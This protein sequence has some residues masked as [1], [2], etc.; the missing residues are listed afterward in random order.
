MKTREELRQEFIKRLGEPQNRKDEYIL[1]QL[2]NVAGKKIVYVVGVHLGESN[3]RKATAEA[4]QELERQGIKDV[5]IV[6]LPGYFSP[7]S[8]MIAEHYGVP[9]KD[10][11]S[12]HMS[13]RPTSKSVEELIRKGIL[14][15]YS[16]SKTSE[17]AI[18]DAIYETI[19]PFVFDI[20][21]YTKQERHKGMT[22]PFFCYG[23]LPWG[24]ELFT[25]II[26]IR[27][28]SKEQ[29]IRQ[30][31]QTKSARG[32]RFWADTSSEKGKKMLEKNKL[33][34]LNFSK[35]LLVWQRR[36]VHPPGEEAGEGKESF[37]EKMLR[38]QA[39]YTKLIDLASKGIGFRRGRK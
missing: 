2:V 3:S 8:E 18:L 37:R 21:N 28:I 30:L 14:P 12:L 7:Y 10:R 34:I 27:K 5:G 15:S 36:G 1:N 38:E 25:P 4:V 22:K 23:D 11:E 32:Y 6:R 9:Q 17:T 20:H 19:T 13:P 35:R 16:L 24:I 26:T 31:L 29:P 39:R 33:F